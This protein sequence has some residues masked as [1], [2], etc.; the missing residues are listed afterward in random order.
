MDDYSRIQFLLLWSPKDED[1]AWIFGYVLCLKK[2]LTPAAAFLSTLS[3][4]LLSAPITPPHQ[5]WDCLSAAS[6]AQVGVNAP[7]QKMKL[8]ENQNVFPAKRQHDLIV[9]AGYKDSTVS[10]FNF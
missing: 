6:L 9:R 10:E 1:A 5:F 2:N 3:T 7:S 4:S 8:Y